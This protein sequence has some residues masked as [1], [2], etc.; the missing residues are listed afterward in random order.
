MQLYITV[1]MFLFFTAVK[2]REG[3]NFQ[4]MTFVSQFRYKILYHL[5]I[6]SAVEKVLFLQLSAKQGNFLH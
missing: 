1:T 4:Q 5:N 2:F 6:G 3:S